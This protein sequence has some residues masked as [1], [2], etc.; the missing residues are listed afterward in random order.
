MNTPIYD[1]AKKYAESRPS[2]MHMPAHKGQIFLGCEP[3]DITEI[4]GADE[5]FA[6]EGIIAESEKNASDIFGCPTFYSTEGSSLCIR[7]MLYLAVQYAVFNGKEPVIAAFRN[8]HRSFM[9]AAVLLDFQPVW[10]NGKADDGLLSQHI[11]VQTIDDFFRNTYPK[12]SA[13]YV[14]SPDYL[15]NIADIRS[16]SEVCR[17][18]GVLLIVDNAHGAYL[19]FL[20]TSQHPIALGADICCDSAH[21]T[22]PVLTGGAYIHFSAKY[23]DFFVPRVKA[24]MSLFASTSPSYLILESLDMCNS[25]LVDNFSEKLLNIM[26]KLDSIRLNLLEKGWKFCG[27]EPM[28]L[29]LS[30]K[31]YGYY[32]AEIADILNKNGIIHEF[33]DKDHVVLMLSYLNTFQEIDKMYS[34]LSG[35]PKKPEITEIPPSME[36][37]HFALPPRQ[38]VLSM[39]E[40]LPVSEC[41]GRICAEIAYSCPPAVP[42]VFCGEVINAEAVRCFEYY[43]ISQILVVKEKF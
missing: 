31:K 6:P 1:F 10:V 33:A 38:A 42:I 7:T 8:V 14:T 21:K 32:G 43:S 13:L 19:H 2:R 39:G 27:N 16:I 17:R 18:Y 37:T 3:Y 11:D 15:G 20:E 9:T 4:G 36:N 26:K 12:P 24:A 35:I 22:L 40:S 34:V 29:T 23:T 28:K 25:I 41:K 30:A 5:L